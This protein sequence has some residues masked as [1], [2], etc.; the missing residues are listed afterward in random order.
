[1]AEA[2]PFPL[3]LSAG[4]AGACASLEE[5]DSCIAVPAPAPM[6]VPPLPDNPT[7]PVPLLPDNL[8]RLT[9]HATPSDGLGERVPDCSERRECFFDLF[10]D[11]VGCADVVTSGVIDFIDDSF[12]FSPKIIF[13][14]LQV[15]D[16]D[17]LYSYKQKGDSSLSVIKNRL[18]LEKKN[19]PNHFSQIKNNLQTENIPIYKN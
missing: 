9:S 7:V 19:T 4:T 13:F 10:G 11:R 8:F 3:A 5:V 18:V 12:A 14:N 17:P 6:P 16:F 2:L 15:L 1:M